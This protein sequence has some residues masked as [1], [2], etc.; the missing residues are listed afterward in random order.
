GIPFH[1]VR[2]NLITGMTPKTWPLV[3]WAE[4]HGKVIAGLLRPTDRPL[5]AADAAFEKLARPDDLKVDQYDRP[6]LRAHLRW[7]AWRT[8]Q[9]AVEPQRAKPRDVFDEAF[10]TDAGWVE[11]KAR[12]ARFKVRWDEQRQEYVATAP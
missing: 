8:V 7:Q 1:N 4:N 6:G 9:S 11:L 5:E 12:V 3:D 10:R 2:F